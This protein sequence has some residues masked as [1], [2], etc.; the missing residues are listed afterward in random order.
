MSAFIAL[1]STTAAGLLETRNTLYPTSPAPGPETCLFPA[2]GQAEP[3]CPGEGG[4]GGFCGPGPGPGAASHQLDAGGVPSAAGLSLS[5]NSGEGFPT[6]PPRRKAFMRSRAP[7]SVWLL[8]RARGSPAAAGK[9]APAA[10]RRHTASSPPRR[11]APPSSPSPVRPGFTHPPCSPR[12]APRWQQTEGPPPPT[13]TS[14]P[15]GLAPG[16]D[17]GPAGGRRVSTFGP[18]RKEKRK[19]KKE[20]KTPI[21]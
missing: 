5:P 7:L 2:A 19:K 16:D 3:R 10:A 12:P 14:V 8:G 15:T 11:G 13:T 6:L 1:P 9:A 17:P 21:T 20:R 18:S 4:G